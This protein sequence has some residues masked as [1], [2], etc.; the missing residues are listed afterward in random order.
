MRTQLVTIRAT[1][2]QA[3]DEEESKMQ[4]NEDEDDAM[5]GDDELEKHASRQ[6]RNQKKK[7][8]VFQDPKY[9]IALTYLQV[10]TASIAV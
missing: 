7:L 2:A 1:G 9:K 5:D 10:S 8:S 3:T 6:V 4:F